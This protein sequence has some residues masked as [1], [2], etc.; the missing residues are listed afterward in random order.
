M[1]LYIDR[2]TLNPL[3]ILYTYSEYPIFVR[4]FSIHD[5]R[6]EERI[7]MLIDIV[8]KS[9]N[10]QSDFATDIRYV[11]ISFMLITDRIRIFNT[12]EHTIY[13]IKMYPHLK[14]SDGEMR[15]IR[16][17]I[18]AFEMAAVSMEQKDEKFIDTFWKGIS[19]MSDCDLFKVE[20]P[21]EKYNT[22]LYMELLCEINKYFT[23]LHQCA[24][25]LDNKMTVLLGIETYSYKRLLEVVEHN[26]FNSISGRTAVR[27]MIENYIMMKYLLLNETI[28]DD[29]WTDFQYYGI[30]Q[31]KIIVA[32]FRDYEV[33]LEQSHVDFNYLE[34]LVNEFI[35]EEFIEM[36]TRYFDKKNI[37]AKAEEVNEKILYGLFYDYDSAFEHGM[38]GAIR[39]S[40]LLKCT[41]PGHH[42]HCVPDCYNQ[43]NLKSVWYDCV[44]VMN[45]TILLLNEIFGLQPDLLKG[46]MKYDEQF[47]IK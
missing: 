9:Y 27:T 15:A 46:I 7:E 3:T 1:L 26:L 45:K 8:N 5:S 11:I 21:T 40:S 39:E 13:S 6:I 38:W 14:H 10:H 23:E 17:T 2:S 24:N 28:H 25:P 20:Y 18:R 36:D 33:N 29:I 22:Q 31:Y 35:R 43:Q 47:T 34:A 42:Y 30:A 37:R 41:S 16:P 44:Y 12:L 19:I 32:R 4:Y